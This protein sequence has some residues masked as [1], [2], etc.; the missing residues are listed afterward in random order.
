VGGSPLD[1]RGGNTS[2]ANPIDEVL[3]TLEIE[4]VS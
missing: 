3:T 4:I 1:R 2:Y